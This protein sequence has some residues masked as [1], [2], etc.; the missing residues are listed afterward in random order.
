MISE[1][2]PPEEVEDEV[3]ALIKTLHETEQRLEELTGGEID[4]VSTGSGRP[5]L[6]R[7]AQEERRNG[8]IARQVAILNA[9]PARVALLDPQ[10]FILSVNE[11]WRRFSGGN[12]MP[13]PEFGV[14]LNYSEIC[15]RAGGD[16]S[17]ES[18]QVAAGVRAV[19]KGETR[20]FSFEYPSHQRAEQRWFQM[21]VTPLADDGKR[22]AVVMHL[23]ITERRLAE[24][25]VRGSEAAMAAAQ[26][27]GHFGS[28]EIE[29]AGAGGTDADTLHWSEEMYRIAGYEP[30]AVEISNRFFFSRVPEK[31]HKT[32]REAVAAAVRDRRQSS[33]VHQFIRA[34]GQACFIQET[35]Q[36]F[37][38][39]KTGR[40]LKIIGTAQDITGRKRSE[41][42][43]A[44]MSTKAVR[45]RRKQALIELAILVAATAVVYCLAARY[46]WLEGF[47]R[48]MMATEADRFNESIVAT[49]FLVVGL[50]GFAFR[51]W[52]ETQSELTSHKHVQAALGLLHVE[53]DWRV[54]RRTAELDKIN[55]TLCGEIAERKRIEAAL[56]TSK[57]HFRMLASLADAMRPLAN[58]DQIMAV[59]ARM[60][61]EHLGASR[62]AYADVDKN[63]ERC[64]I[65]QDYTDGC[66]SI[67]GN[68]PLWLFG[69][70]GVATLNDGQ[71]LII[72]NGE[73]ELLPGEGADLFKAIGARAIIICPLV[74][75]GGL[76]AMIAVHQS[77]PR[78]WQPNE[79]AIA[80]EV[81]TRCRATIER[82]ATEE[83][84]HKSEAMLRIAGRTAR[85]GGWSVELPELRTTWSAE[86]CAIHEVPPG[87]V[88]TLQEAM[89]FYTP[90]SRERISQVF[91]ACVEKGISFDLELEI[92]TAKG[93]RVG[94]RSIG[95]AKR[96]A[97]GV[98]T[99]VQGAFQDITERKQIAD[100]LR[101]SEKRFKALFEQAAVGVAQTDATTGR[102]V[103]INQRFCEIL[104]RSREELE[105]LT[106]VELTHPQDLVLS[107][108]MA[109][110]IKAGPLR[111]FTEEK[112]YLRKD[113]SE[114][115]A[116]VTVSAMWAPGEV[117]DYFIAVAQDITGRKKLE[118][119]FRQSQKMDAIGT[120]AGGIAH[121]FNNILAAINGYTELS[122]IQLT[123]NPEV[124][125]Y[126]RAVL[127]A[128]GRATELVRQILTFSR[129]QK[130]ERRP[131][132]LQPIVTEAFKLLRASIPSTIEFEISLKDAPVV[133]ADAAQIHQ[134][135]M[136]LG[137]N[138]SHAMKDRPGKLLVKLERSV[139][140]SSSA[141]LRAR[142]NPGEYARL[143]VSDSGS[144]MD[145]E[146]L[147]RIFEPFFTTKPI[148]EGT[149]LGLAVV[150]GIMATHDGAITV[151]SEP[152]EGT[153]FHLYFP[154]FAGA[155]AAAIELGEVPRGN[156]ERILF[157]D[158]EE[159]L[160]QLGE[161]TLT[162]LGYVVEVTTQS[163]AALAMVRADPQ[164]FALVLTDQTMPGMAGIDLARQLLQIRPGLPIML[165]TGYGLL[166]TSERVK[167]AGIRHLLHKP[168]T[169]HSLGSAVHAAISAQSPN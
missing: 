4:T 11:S 145:Q 42:I 160:V 138:A 83:T 24:N 111:E 21:T 133:L 119:Q 118:D 59:A 56:Q 99:R 92:L 114:V 159:L 8:E 135:L 106:F 139:I 158:D 62:S 34:D 39:D 12:A 94:V 108:D 65:R 121:D 70:Q 49:I 30:G 28:W 168:A 15:E 78:D 141:S 20:S 3:S 14:G 117:P 97:A 126:L 169:I 152:G 165:L 10:G 151:Y 156:G 52:R 35:A 33:F 16:R 143:S 100:E 90:Q 32:I 7:R 72:R 112:R 164:R 25:A 147:K 53:L 86:V 64:T 105:L 79:V 76:R 58:P 81:A 40:P 113:D 110:Q 103:Q 136:N 29:L 43:V 129:Q 162:A 18:Q 48:R 38:D 91:R 155:A 84:L 75:E 37:F 89:G 115:W 123:G 93:N 31:E 87:T 60:L 44:E 73:T 148:G 116:T 127:Q 167:A 131:T 1:S 19:L 51:R 41:E 26:R 77:T 74:T 47:T 161:K 130:L 46:D 88:P 140:D 63:G 95:E 132:Q 61:G 71:T 96:D 125:N 57:E 163:T 27:I 101:A 67:A 124:R 149:G 150:H 68:Y 166:L 69:V 153:V 5:F 120:L 13:A 82:R 144:G 154:A 55:Q 50:A 36:V 104:G 66:A 2:L 80:Q 134:V 9:L 54:K 107:L 6:L 109:R 128:S 98:I 22:G 146:T 137:T 23:N 17:S 157:V 102:F 45:S 122:E 142:L 85:L